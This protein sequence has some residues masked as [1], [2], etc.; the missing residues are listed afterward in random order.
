MTVLYLFNTVPTGTEMATRTRFG[1]PAFG[2]VSMLPAQLSYSSCPRL[3]HL[4]LE[5][6]G[7]LYTKKINRKAFYNHHETGFS[8]LFWESF[9]RYN[10]VLL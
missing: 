10:P 8:E 3:Y 6:R 9:F 1:R 4:K 5:L 2:R 7:Q